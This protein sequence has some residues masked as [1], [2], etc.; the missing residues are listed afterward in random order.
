M[1]RWKVILA[2]LLAGGLISG[3]TG[4]QSVAGYPVW[5]GGRAHQGQKVIAQYRCGSCHSIPGIRD[6][7]GVFGPPLVAM[8]RRS[9]IAGIFPNEP[10]TLVR[11]IKSPESMK[12]K[13]AMPNLGLSDQEARDAAAYLYTLR[14]APEP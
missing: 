14:Q 3:C 9:Y 1:H 7:D 2:L 5:T 13:T 6:A 12:P 11:W 10:E 4:G 8:G